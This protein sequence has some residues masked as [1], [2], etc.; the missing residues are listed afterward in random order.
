[1]KRFAGKTAVITG[2]CSG[3]GKAAAHRLGAEGCRIIIVDK[4]AAR[5]PVTVDELRR[6]GSEAQFVPADLADQGQIEQMAVQAGAHAG[7]I[8]VLV[9]S[10]G[11]LREK[12]LEQL[13]AADWEPITAV[14]LRAPLMVSLALLPWLKKPGGAIVN[15]AA[16]G[17]LKARDT[18]AIYDATK[19]GLISLTKSCAVAFAK[20][21]IR[22]NVVAPGAVVTEIHYATAANPE[23]RRQE[24]EQ[25]ILERYNLQRRRGLPDEV[26]GAIAFLA[27]DEASFIT[28]TVLVIDGGNVGF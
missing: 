12:P 13:T 10:A 5:G 7:S 3:I 6:L 8:D 20:H 22:V 4:D 2:G 25:E 28:G 11:I 15:L 16:G 18:Q 27:S 9:N 24:L 26:S 21:G 1:M 19:A 23:Q 14:N 17:A